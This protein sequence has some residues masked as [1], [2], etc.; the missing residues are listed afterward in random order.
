MGARVEI[1]FLGGAQQV[2]SLG[3]VLHDG[4]HKVLFDYGMTPSDPPEYPL[5]LPPGIEQVFLSHCHLDHSGMAPVATRG[6]HTQMVTTQMT[7]TVAELLLYDSIKIARAERY[8]EPFST[9]EL[10]DWTVRT[11]GLPPKEVF[12]APG[13][14]VDLTSAGHVPGAA[15]FRWH[16]KRDVLFTGD[17]HTRPTHL[18]LGAQPLDA[19]VLVMES[20]YAGRE[21]PDRQEEDDR[22]RKEVERVVSQGGQVIVPAFA[23]GRT[24]EIL[25]TLAD[26]GYNIWVDGMGRAVNEMYLDRPEYI[27]DPRLLER[28]IQSSYTVEDAY[29]RET[30]LNEAEVIVTTGGMLDGGPV[31]HYLKT[32]HRDP[33]NAL[34]LVGFQVEGSNGRQLVDT[35]AI[36]F[37][38]RT[39]RPKMEIK[40]F[41]FS[42][43]AGH[44]D[45]LDLAQKVKPRTVVLMHGDQRERLAEDLRKDFE[46][47]L[48]M[49][50]E[51]ITL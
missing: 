46:V 15:M 26:S 6:A 18:V 33:K 11:L 34:F 28:A 43:H 25:I 16:G 4:G 50:G 8:P 1:R 27:K 40:R 32:L 41:D 48:P 14:E 10:K 38:E 45:L 30:A 22:F 5:P 29:D 31:L 2:G 36:T 12:R 42:S 37:D 47:L 24:Q 7:R 17:V 39:L 20:T 21:H 23:V 9:K 3:M 13:V 44:S 51:T 19:D 49:N 35:G